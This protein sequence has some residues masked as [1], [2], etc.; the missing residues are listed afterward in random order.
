MQTELHLLQS[1]NTITVKPINSSY[2]VFLSHSSLEYCFFNSFL[3]DEHSSKCFLSNKISSQHCLGL[4]SLEQFSPRA[5]QQRKISTLDTS[6]LLRI[7]NMDQLLN[8]FH[9]DLLQGE[10]EQLMKPK[11]LCIHFAVELFHRVCT[12]V[13]DTHM[14]VC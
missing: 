9:C 7:R 5:S 3:V 8:T 13:Q 1:I 10:F 4:R 6:C 11:V 2:Q 12:S 14:H